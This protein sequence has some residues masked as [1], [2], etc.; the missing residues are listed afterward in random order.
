MKRILLTLSG[1]LLF[2]ASLSAQITINKF[3]AVPTSGTVFGRDAVGT[4]AFDTTITIFRED[5]DTSAHSFVNANFD[6][7][8]GTFTW[9]SNGVIHNSTLFT[10]FDSSGFVMMNSEAL[11][12]T[13]TQRVYF[14]SPSFSTVNYN[15]VTLYLNHFYSNASSDSVA[16][17]MISTNG[18]TWN[19]L[20]NYAADSADRGTSTA[21]ANDTF[22]L[23]AQYLNKPAV[24]LR[25]VYATSAGMYWAVNDVLVRGEKFTPSYHTVRRG[26]NMTWDLS[27]ITYDGNTNYYLRRSSPAPY[28][29]ADSLYNHELK[30]MTHTTYDLNYFTIQGIFAWGHLTY[31]HTLP[32]GSYTGNALDSLK[33]P[34]QPEID[35]S[36]AHTKVA[37]PLTFNTRWKSDFWFTEKDSVKGPSFNFSTFWP[38]SRV[39]QHS[40]RDTVVGW[41]KM[42]VKSVGGNVESYI[43]VLQIK[44]DITLKDSFFLTVR[45]GVPA[46][47]TQKS[48][49]SLFLANDAGL[50]ASTHTH[51]YTKYSFM[52]VGEL[53]PLVT[54]YTGYN[55]TFIT[56]IEVHKDHPWPLDVMN[57]SVTEEAL[58]VYPNPVTG[59]IVNVS[60]STP[61]EGN[62]GCDVLN[63]M[64]QVVATQALNL[65]MGNTTARVNLP[66]SVAP[67]TYYLRF[68]R[69]GELM[70]VKP[71]T[72][73]E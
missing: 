15:R 22:W 55:D 52:R 8:G 1:V 34:E 26:A 48:L 32:L 13:D 16:A 45:N 50:S 66:A 39:R 57:P 63:V 7:Y 30:G 67:G 46:D 47:S 41:G 2:A 33:V 20:R 23:T 73:Q 64:G 44:S 10:T 71:V 12:S 28:R 24:Y 40:Q 6:G 60:L 56:K 29:F 3:N 25:F 18:T 59:R 35:Y 37:Y 43:D 5:F 65:D 11:G 38:L 17:L 58:K 72:V 14:T 68:T 53:H 49:F 51:Q 19:V 21:F 31:L 4:L 54:V 62:W 61:Q 70:A 36:N 42:R 69:N 27:G 9:D